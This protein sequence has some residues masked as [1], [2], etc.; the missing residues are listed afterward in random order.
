[1]NPFTLKLEDKI[2]M[3]KIYIKENI[4]RATKTTAINQENK[5]KE[6]NERGPV[7][8]WFK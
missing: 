6:K 2:S 7:K 5:M 3:K 4:E 8:S 1:M